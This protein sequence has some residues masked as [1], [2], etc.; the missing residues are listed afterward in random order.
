MAAARWVL[1]L[2]VRVSSLSDAKE[3]H[4]RRHATIIQAAGRAL[5]C[6]EHEVEI[7]RSHATARTE[8]ALDPV[9]SEALR[10]ESA[11]DDQLVERHP[12]HAPG[13]VR[14]AFVETEATSPFAF[15]A[16]F[17]S[18]KY[19]RQC[20]IFI[21]IMTLFGFFWKWLQKTCGKHFPEGFFASGQHGDYAA[22]RCLVCLHTVANADPDAEYSAWTLT[23][24]AGR[25]G[26]KPPE[27]SLDETR[28]ED[29]TPLAAQASSSS[30][31]P[32]L[33][34]VMLP[35][36]RPELQIAL[37]TKPGSFAR[38]KYYGCT[39][40]DVAEDLASLEK[41]GV[42]KSLTIKSEK[43]KDKGQLV[44]S[45]YREGSTSRR[46]GAWDQD[47]LP[48]PTICALDQAVERLRV[49]G[50]SERVSKCDTLAEVLTGN[51][52]LA[53][54]AGASVPRYFSMMRKKTKWFW[55]WYQDAH[56]DWP[57]PLPAKSDNSRRGFLPVRTIVN[58]FVTK[59]DRSSFIVR[60]RAED[61]SVKELVLAR[62][63]RP[64]MPFEDVVRGRDELLWALRTMR[65]EVLAGDDG[66]E[67]SETDA[68]SVASEVVS[69]EADTG[70]PSRHK[71]SRPTRSRSPAP[72]PARSASE[73]TAPRT[74][75]ETGR[76]S[77]T[78]LAPPP[79][80]R[81]S[82]VDRK[83]RDREDRNRGSSNRSSSPANSDDRRQR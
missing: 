20:G 59:D 78:T 62:N 83:R 52:L 55:V 75:T 30:T 11:E 32:T 54:K 16:G 3:P 70:G 23:R 56:P 35:P 47:R 42:Q 66:S 81:A 45:F 53:N 9:P 60:Y 12:P 1:L 79:A 39:T 73:A 19:L 36:R 48:L 63:D 69:E 37:F 6:D 2:A 50:H 77:R 24:P 76:S 21:F 29:G 7:R 17:C 22:F 68:D 27:A 4:A 67:A 14:V 46:F 5:D 10:R 28:V 74:T 25:G 80:Q 65:D 31:W 44:V 71:G 38:P 8:A 13:P 61:K 58:A 15:A 49:K 64:R 72:A 33:L 34:E 82:S 57:K 41:P 43:K 26:D 18:A 51:F 40:V